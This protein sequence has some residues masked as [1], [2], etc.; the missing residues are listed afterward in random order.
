MH[1]WVFQGNNLAPMKNCPWGARQVKLD[2]WVIDKEAFI[3]I[4]S[5]ISVPFP[6]ISP[7][8]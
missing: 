6:H 2:P 1:L 4:I 3:I 5:H 7:L 8:T